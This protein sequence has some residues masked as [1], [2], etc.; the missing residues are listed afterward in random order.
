VE[1][2]EAEVLLPSNILGTTQGNGQISAAKMTLN[3]KDAQPVQPQATA[4]SKVLLVE[5]NIINMK[6]RIAIPRSNGEKL[7]YF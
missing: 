1:R 7:T 3:L 6:V 2:E 4:R 5:D